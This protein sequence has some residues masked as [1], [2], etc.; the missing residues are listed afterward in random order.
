MTLM[1]RMAKPLWEIW[2][3]V[4]MDSVFCV[5]EGLI[6]MYDI[7]VYGSSL[8]KKRGY[9]P[10]GINGNQINAHFEKKEIGEHDCHSGNWKGF[11]FDVFVVK[12]L[13]YNMIMM[14]TYSGIM[15]RDDQKEEYH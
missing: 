5:L 12:D 11:D 6:G 8:V 14:P 2:K 13:N 15:V 7:G 1:G 4:I 10:S 9:W 3:T